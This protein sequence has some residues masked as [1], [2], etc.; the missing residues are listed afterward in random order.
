[1]EFKTLQELI[2]IVDNALAVQFYGHSGVLRKSVLKVLATVLGGMLYMFSLMVKRIWKNRFVTTCDLSALDG[3][4]E[5]YGVPHKAPLCAKGAVQVTLASEVE[6]VTVPAGT[7]LV[8]RATN[9]EY[10]TYQSVEVSDT[11]N[12]IPVIAVTPGKE[13]D[14]S[15]GAELQFR[16]SDIEGIESIESMEIYGGVSVDVEIDGLI[17]RWGETA[18]EYRQRLLQRVRNP[19][20]GGASSDYESW[21]TRFSGVSRAFVYPN[22]PNANSVSV[23]LGNFDNDDPAVPASIV[24]E[25]SNYVNSETR[26]PITA[27]VR[28]FSVTPVTVSIEASVAPFTQSVRESVEKAIRRVFSETSPGETLLFSDVERNVLANSTASE[29]VI[30]NAQKDGTAVSSFEMALNVP[31][32]GSPVAQ[33]AKFVDD[34]DDITINLVNGES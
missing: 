6:S 23:A 29:F 22:T 24:D 20:H 27:D 7:F 1:M 28:V 31:V 14:L 8:D 3:F 33:V 21:A 16:D 5:E 30:V 19:L 17:Y 12:E 10:E 9:L 26:R 13:S 4:G 2:R 18:E 32:S 34:S 25:V 11:N 15:A